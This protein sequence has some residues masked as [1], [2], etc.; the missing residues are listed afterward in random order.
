MPAMLHLAAVAALRPDSGAEPLPTRQAHAARLLG[1]ADA[2]LAVL[3]APRQFTEQQEYDRVL[4]RLAQTFG[5][6]ELAE[7]MACGAEMTEDSAVD[8][9]MSAWQ[10]GSLQ[11]K[12]VDAGRQR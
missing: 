3:G 10:A 2:R 11:A 6:D 5:S 1:Y 8:E 7:L 9:A 4:D 12:E